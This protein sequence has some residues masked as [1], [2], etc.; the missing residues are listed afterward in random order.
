MARR[1]EPCGARKND[2]ADAA[3]GSTFSHTGPAAGA[4]EVGA[5]LHPAAADGSG[6]DDDSDGDGAACASMASQSVM[7]AAGGPLRVDTS[8]P[9]A[10][11]APATAS[12]D[13]AC[14]PCAGEQQSVDAAASPQASLDGTPRVVYTVDRHAQPWAH[15]ALMDLANDGGEV[16]LDL[17]REAP[18]AALRPTSDRRRRRRLSPRDDRPA[19]TSPSIT[20]RYD[21]ERDAIYVHKHA[22]VPTTPAL[23]AAAAAALPAG[24]PS[25]HK[26]VESAGRVWTAWDAIL[27]LRGRG[28]DAAWPPG[29]VAVLGTSTTLLP[30]QD[31]VLATT[32]MRGGV[33]DLFGFVANI[34]RVTSMP[35]GAAVSSAGMPAPRPL[36]HDAHAR[37]V[38][39]TLRAAWAATAQGL[40]HMH[41]R[42]VAHCD[43]KPEN[44]VL[45]PTRAV[46]TREGKALSCALHNAQ[47][48][49]APIRL[50]TWLTWV[51]A[52][53]PVAEL[54]DLDL[55]AV[56]PGG[57]GH[58]PRLP[59]RRGTR[60]YCAPEVLSGQTG[61]AAFAADAWSLGASILRM[62]SLDRIATALAAAG[63]VSLAT[64]YAVLGRKGHALLPSASIAQDDALSPSAGTARDMLPACPSPPHAP[65]SN[66]STRQGNPRRI[67]L[68]TQA[69]PLVRRFTDVF[70][71]APAPRRDD[72]AQRAPE[73]LLEHAVAHAPKCFS[74]AQWAGILQCFLHTPARRPTLQA[75]A[76][77]LRAHTH[78]ALIAALD[79]AMARLVGDAPPH[80]ARSQASS[81]DG[82]SSAGNATPTPWT[83]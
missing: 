25:M 50:D 7:P 51:A 73:A 33:T 71:N 44:I 61:A 68:A 66:V 75:L 29:V 62:H 58:E 57:P 78:T 12:F 3:S 64:W 31:A 60:A 34:M 15:D 63:G 52:A 47:Q 16:L 41:A 26:V 54:I 28:L 80:G 83:P 72:G 65:T 37:W 21:M 76:I 79:G 32:A 17:A 69:T 70:P 55:A 6:G 14:S 5:L 56:A 19:P 27:A 35:E 74:P 38:G 49:D 22:F 2:G 39:L 43:V 59:G 81:D 45:S 48:G 13:T 30:Q 46:F 36:P 24:L 40:A 20:H 23:R 42:G 9:P 1:G 10:T 8:A 11:T 53:R 4:M 82:S 18:H 77:C 67:T